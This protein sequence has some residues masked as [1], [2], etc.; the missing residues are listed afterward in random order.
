[1]PGPLIGNEKTGA[2]AGEKQSSVCALMWSKVPRR[3]FVQA[4]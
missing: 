2:I 3:R 1:M 4:E